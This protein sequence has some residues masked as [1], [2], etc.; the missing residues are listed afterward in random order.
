MNGTGAR[1]VRLGVGLALLVTLGWVLTGQ[2]AKPVKK[3]ISLP[4]DWSH[5]HMIFSG[6]RTP[7]Q[8]ARVS[9]DPRYWQQVMR[10][11]MAAASVR[12]DHSP[13]RGNVKPMHRDWAV[14]LGTG[15][16][17]GA[18]NYPAKFSFDITQADCVNDYVIFNT[19][20]L[21]SGT[22]ASIVGFNNLYS[23]CGGT[24]PTVN[25]A[26]NTG[27]AVLTSPVTSLDGTQ[28]A[29]VESNGGFGILV[30]LKWAAGTG[31]IG[32]P[33]APT[34]VLPGL[35]PACSA[36]CMTQILLK[37]G[38]NNQTDD[39]TSSVY[40]DYTNDV[41]WVGG[42]LGWLHKITGMFNGTPAEVHAGGF[43]A[44]VNATTWT[45][46]P[47]Y[48]RL[49]NRV[50]LG[51]ASGFLYAVDATS[52][53]VTASGQLDFGTGLV[54]GPVVDT[55]NGFVYAFAS[56]DGT[57]NCGG[58]AVACSAVYQLSTSF[59]ASDIGS[60]VTVGDSVDPAG[61]TNPN[62]MYIGGFDSSY[63]ASNNATG[64]LY[65]CGNTGA[66]ATLYQVPITAGAFP[67][68]GQGLSITALTTVAS[69]AA[70]S[71]VTD[72][73]NPNTA[74]G[75]SERAF[76]SA[77]N[78][79]RSVACATSGCVFNFLTTPWQA[80]HVYSVGQEILSS[81]LHIETVIQAGTSAASTPTWTNSA[82]L[83]RNDGTVIW[84]DQGLLSAV[85]ISG[86]QPNHTYARGSRVPDEAGN[87][88]V[89]TNVGGGTSG[90]IEP[91]WNPIVGGT[92]VD[93][94]AT[95]TNV[96]PL[97]TFAAE[98]MGGSSG[99]IEDNVVGSGTLAGAS[100]VYFS[101][102]AD[103]TCITSGTSGGCATQASQPKLQ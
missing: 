5:R 27:G 99:I 37:D 12:P 63:Y 28:V 33:A 88:E 101:T 91:T 58:G 62:P 16:A 57:T 19:G 26:Y 64:N 102:L 22:Q 43:P 81:K 93:N 92:V 41:A 52:G 35:Y 24:L 31:T 11:E 9:Q 36:P 72:V 66:N 13:G 46:S 4:T 85:A 2:A 67:L 3:R 40:Y 54:A 82:G 73:P 32:T 76:V 80:S 30:V 75:S 20:L 29:F 94:T 18:G 74:G 49:T 78:Q 1:F 61:S 17:V 45:S 83:T 98:S 44:H 97:A 95:W 21:G 14:N 34:L 96:G 8:F 86:W 77:Q 55:N 48:D 39:T 79:G 6:A 87:I 70:C 25:W 100:Q 71:P 53:T 65:V 89:V 23:G 69:T 42:A 84:M 103:Q 10:R 60:E 56:S 50:F 7:E 15:A 68:S 90:A 47:V 51:D 38:S 59:V